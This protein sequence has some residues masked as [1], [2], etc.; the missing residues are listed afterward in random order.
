MIA[1]DLSLNLYDMSY[2]LPF[3]PELK[4][5]ILPTVIMRDLHQNDS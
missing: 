2:M 3:L 1:M 4:T 5:R